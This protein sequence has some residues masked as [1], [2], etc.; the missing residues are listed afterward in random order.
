MSNQAV[1]VVDCWRAIL[2]F[3]CSCVLFSP[4]VTHCRF[5]KCTCNTCTEGYLSCIGY[6]NN[7]YTASMEEIY[8]QSKYCFTQRCILNDFESSTEFWV[9]LNSWILNAVNPKL[10]WIPPRNHETFAAAMA[11]AKAV[12]FTRSSQPFR[13]NHSVVTNQKSHNKNSSLYGSRSR[14]N[15]NRIIVH[16]WYLQHSAMEENT[17]LYF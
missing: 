2:C 10:H 11:T 5:G 14:L 3:I 13:F 6:S 16:D 12:L 1:K 15:H 9:F 17:A 7:R 4:N 8:R